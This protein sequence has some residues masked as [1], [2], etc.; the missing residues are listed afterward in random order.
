[1]LRA[2]AFAGLAI[3]ESMLGAAHSLA[4]PL[5]ARH[6]LPH[7]EAVGRMLPHVVRHNAEDGPTA[8]VYRDLAAAAGLCAADAP[9]RE[10]AE[11]LARRLEALLAAAGLAGPLALLGA[12]LDALAAEAATQWTAQF[13]PRPVDAAALRALY[14][15]ALRTVPGQ[16]P[17]D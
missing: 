2:A 16:S 10:A 7:G 13:N 9:P 3:E 12:D 5:T 17:D 14:A 11:L 15:R 6:D 8:S 4:N 1:M